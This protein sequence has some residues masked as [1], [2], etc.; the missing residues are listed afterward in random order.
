MAHIH[1]FH[2]AYSVFGATMPMEGL[3]GHLTQAV[4]GN[5]TSAPPP[6]PFL[7]SSFY[8]KQKLDRVGCPCGLLQQMCQLVL[9]ALQKS[10]AKI[11]LFS[12]CFLSI[13]S[14]WSGWTPVTSTTEKQKGSADPLFPTNIPLGSHLSRSETRFPS[15]AP[16]TLSCLVGRV[17]LQK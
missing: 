1:V 12:C 5:G 11:P 14:F 3:Q 15:S 13:L 4:D 6:S 16:F 9:E 7:V 2:L 17:P 8:K 10:N